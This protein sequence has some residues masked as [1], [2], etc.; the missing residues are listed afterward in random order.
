MSS[1]SNIARAL[2]RTS[3][4]L[5]QHRTLSGVSG[6]QYKKSWVPQDDLV[7]RLVIIFPYSV[8]II[9][10]GVA[11]IFDLLMRRLIFLIGRVVSF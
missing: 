7:T 8:S 11:S 5:A 2:V 10:M 1:R 3:T 4:P 9:G 6:N